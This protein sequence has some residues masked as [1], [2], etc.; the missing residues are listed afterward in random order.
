MQLTA[1]KAIS[2]R[3]RKLIGRGLISKIC[4]DLI[5]QCDTLISE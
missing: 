5:P 4:T 1:N 2:S 3:N